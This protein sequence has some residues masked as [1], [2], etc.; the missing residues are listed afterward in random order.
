MN[1]S[2]KSKFVMA[3]GAVLLLGVMLLPSMA[4]S[5]A[6]QTSTKA[7]PIQI[8]KIVTAT[9]AE[10]YNWAGYAINAVPGTVTYV[11]GS[12]VEPKDVGKTCDSTGINAASFWVGIDGFKDGSVEQTGTTVTCQLGVNYYYAWYEF[13][14][15]PTVVISSINLHPGDKMWASVTYTKSGAF[16]VT[17]SDLTT[18]QSLTKTIRDPGVQRSSAE[19]IAE[20]PSFEIGEAILTNF[21]SV[22]FTD[23]W[24]TVNGKTA[25]IGGFGQKTV[26]INA[27]DFPV[28]PVKMST[29]SL[30]S[31]GTSFTTTWLHPGP[32]GP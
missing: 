14:P 1:L 23:G 10:S 15:L 4:F 7:P 12:W 25:S 16:V 32:Y 11:Q 26:L 31:G 8:A 22:H 27:I 9:K 24:A 28:G 29:S 19:W 30:S 6:I 13:Y 21:G 5:N 2:K 20:S 17:I 18:G 3:T